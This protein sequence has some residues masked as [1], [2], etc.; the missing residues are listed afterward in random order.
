ME[1][2]D[3][4]QAL[5]ELALAMVVTAEAMVD[6]SGQGV[7]IRVG[8]ASGPVVAGVVG[9][10]KFFYD[11]WG[12]T[13]NLAARMESTGEPGRIQVTRRTRDLLAAEYSLAR[14][15]GNVEVKGKGPMATWFLLGRRQEAATTIA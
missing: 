7:P 3:H 13:V 6:P 9:T 10:K 4:A 1:R 5:A 8:I 12:D 15:R 11:V 2:S 14:R